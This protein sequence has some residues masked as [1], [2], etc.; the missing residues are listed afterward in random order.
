[1]NDIDV[2][3]LTPNN[4]Y[5]MDWYDQCISS[6]SNHPINIHHLNSVDGDIRQAR[7]HGFAAGSA[8]YVSFVDVDD[9]INEGSYEACLDVFN[10]NPDICGVYTTST[11]V[12][13]DGAGREYN[14]GLIHP[15]RPWSIDAGR[16]NIAEIHQLVVMKRNLLTDLYKTVYNDIPKMAYSELYLYWALAHIAPWKAVDFVGYNWRDHRAGSHHHRID[17]MELRRC[18]GVIRQNHR[19][20]LL[21]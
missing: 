7:Q 10:H 3:I 15:Y 21:Y 14:K 18:V 2:H 12:K 17:E 5:R 9:Y 19:P 4:Y 8:P 11:H 13:V 1:M 20:F 6:L 16:T